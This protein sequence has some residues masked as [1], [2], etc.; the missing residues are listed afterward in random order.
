MHLVLVHQGLC[1]ALEALLGL[2]VGALLRLEARLHRVHLRLHDRHLCPVAH[3]VHDDRQHADARRQRARG[4]GGPPGQARRRVHGFEQVADDRDG[5]VRPEVRHRLGHDLH[6]LSRDG[7][8]RRQRCRAARR[9]RQH[10][11][12]SAAALLLPAGGADRDA[13][14][15][16][17]GAASGALA[18]SRCTKQR[19]LCASSGGV[20]QPRREHGLGGMGRPVCLLHVFTGYATCQSRDQL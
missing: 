3:R 4:D 14:P 7:V 13:T 10:C 6:R 19:R 15:V 12:R 17:E 5:R 18:A 20:H 1:V 9:L 2:G 8:R 11:I 16:D